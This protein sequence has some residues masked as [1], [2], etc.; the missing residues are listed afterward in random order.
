LL[1]VS[2]LLA[3]IVTMPTR[4]ISGSRAAP[5]ASHTAALGN[6]TSAFALIGSL[7]G[8]AARVQVV[9][10]R[11]YLGGSGS[12]RIVDV[13]DP[14]APSVLGSYPAAVADLQVVGDLAYVAGAGGL[15]IVGVADAANPTLRGTYDLPQAGDIFDQSASRVQVVGSHAYVLFQQAIQAIPPYRTELAIVDVRD[16]SKPVLRSRFPLG[17]SFNDLS[18]ESGYAYIGGTTD[19]GGTARF[20]SFYLTVLDVRD[21]TH[22]IVLGRYQDTDVLYHASTGAIAVADGVAYLGLSSG[23][24]LY[25][26]DVRDPNHPLPLGSLDMKVADVRVDGQVVYSV[27]TTFGLAVLDARDPSVPAVRATYGLPGTPSGL[28]IAGD[29]LYLAAGDAGLRIVRFTPR[30]TAAIP[31]GGGTLAATQGT[32]AYE[33]PAG[34]F[35]DTALVTHT[36]RLGGDLPP[37]PALVRIG[38]AFE[39]TAT[40]SATGQPAQPA[41]PYTI[42][43]SYTDA[44]RA[45]AIADTPALYFWDGV[46]WVREPTSALDQ[47]ARTVTAAST[48]LGLWALLGQSRRQLLPVVSR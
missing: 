33:F 43:I 28:D 44:A 40:L 29:L 41:L 23:P 15:V 2:A 12:L 22:P 21:P 1:L 9:G 3:L 30:T 34:A 25:T 35:A 24:A 11:A 13:G 45:P 4:S 38:H 42:T 16:P 26:F 47:P 14:A 18:V 20:F 19:F 37:A 6:D 17:P 5:A 7:G 39:L 48:R 8:S 36:L 32:I 31:P 10:R 46:A 27:G